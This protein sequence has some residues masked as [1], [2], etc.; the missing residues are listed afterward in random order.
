VTAVPRRV[1]AA[2]AFLAAP[3]VRA[4]LAFL[5]APTVRAAL[6]ALGALAALAGLVLAR[7]GPAEAA[8]PWPA[9]RSGPSPATGPEA[10]GLAPGGELAADGGPAPAGGILQPG[11]R[12]PAVRTLQQRLAELHYYPGPRNGYFGIDTLEAVWAFKEVQGLPTA[13]GPDQVGP[14]MRRALAAPRLPTVLVP[15]GGRLRIEVDLTREVLVLYRR[16]QVELIS[17]I[18]AGGGYYYHCPGG[19][20][21]GPAI[22]PDG[23]YRARWFAGGWLHVPLGRMY[24]PVFFIGA[25]FAIHGDV[26]IPLRPASHGCV[27]VPVDIA[28]FLYTRIRIRQPGGTPIYIRGHAPGTWPPPPRPAGPRLPRL[29]P[30]PAASPLGPQVPGLLP[31]TVPR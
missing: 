12:G 24:N 7:P 10:G 11:T 13:S 6:A 5:A 22:T 4:A 31:L 23:N 20:I 30:Q 14:A 21:C 2:L 29:A 1:L 16:G 8:A 15:S 9:G 18:S 28:R 27:R 19:G 3:T 17:H 25:N 26:P